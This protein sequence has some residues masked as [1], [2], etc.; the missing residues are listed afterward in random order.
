M[1]EAAS[2]SSVSFGT[3]G[4]GGG[5][6]AQI[7]RIFA[8]LNPEQRRAVE[9][10]RGP[11]VIMAGAGSGKTST[12]TRRIA[13]QVVSGEFEPKNI[14]AVTYT[15]KAAA[16]LGER[17]AKLGASGVPARTFHA[18][19]LSQLTVLGQ[20][21]VEVLEAKTRLLWQIRSGLPKEFKEQHLGELAGEIER[22]KN[23]RITPDR[24]LDE[25]AGV[26]PIP[27][28]LMQHVFATYEERKRG[29]RKLDF[30]DLLELAIRMYETSPQ[31]LE[32]F[33]ARYRAITVD[34]YQDVNLLQQTLLDRWL[35][36]REDVC[37]VGDDYQAIFGFTG[38]SPRYLLA[39]RD[40]FSHGTVVTLETNY[41]ST[42]EVLAWANRLAPK[43]DG[44]PK[45]LRADRGDGPEPVLRN[46]PNDDAELDYIVGR[47]RQLLAAGTPA[48]EIAILY[49]INARSISFEKALHD[50]EIPFQVAAGGFL[51]RQAWRGIRKRLPAKQMLTDVRAVI[52]AELDQAG[53]V[54][55]ISA[56]Q[57][58][59]QEYTRQIDLGFIAE[60]AGEFDDGERTIAQFVLWVE[61][62]FS[63]YADAETKD[64]VRLSTY[65]LAK[66]LEWEAVFMPSLRDGE[67]PYWRADSPAEIASERRLFYVGLTRAKTILELSN[68]GIAHPSR[69]LDEAAPPRTDKPR[70]RQP[71]ATP[72]NGPW[73][74]GRAAWPSDIKVTTITGGKTPLSPTRFRELIADAEAL[75]REGSRGTGRH[76]RE[77]NPWTPAEDE[78]LRELH[79]GGETVDEIAELLK[80]KPTS[81]YFRLHT[82]GS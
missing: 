51:E 46:H 70:A 80:R 67:L 49:R 18:A 39:M 77:R 40:R 24:Y 36:R 72:S 22:A 4:G 43:L 8:G 13:H 61:D 32:R 37:V 59:P 73:P 81:L 45:K 52:A 6:A 41:R 42:P 50:A 63:T 15:T 44:L 2:A 47:I 20:M 71:R 60:L 29:M 28:E 76:R 57:V 33:Q 82:L 75:V 9:A 27:A 14:L 58:S 16:E 30:E 79:G 17:L 69:F 7:E 31:A 54:P 78:I 38:A 23:N 34:E 65:H 26:P 25:L 12:I 55:N 56:A 64:A 35:G 53:Y 48:K 66:G 62:Q 11:V 5:K 74:T 3:P 10:I 68:A 19:A 1:H 21:Q